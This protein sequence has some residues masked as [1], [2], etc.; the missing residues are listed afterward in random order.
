MTQ[1]AQIFYHDI[2]DYLTREKK[3]EI[4][5]EF[6]SIKNVPWQILTPNE[7]GDWISQRNSIF[8]TFIPLAPEKKFDE[9]SYA[10]FNINAI[11][12]S[13]NR[14]AWVYNFS[15]KELKK[16]IKKTIN[17]FN[18][19]PDTN[20]PAKISWTVNLKKDAENNIKHKFNENSIIKSLYRPFTEQ[21]LYYDKSLVER[22]GIWQQFFPTKE[23]KNL[24]ICLEGTGSN[25]GFGCLIT[26]KIS[27]LG[28]AGIHTQ[29]FPL[30]YYTKK[31]NKNKAQGEI[32]E[33]EAEYTRQNGVSDFIFNQ[34]K[35]RYGSKVSRED[36]FYYA[37]GIL[38]S[39]S[40]RKTFANDLK[41]MLPRL[42]LVENAE[43]FQ[44]FSASGRKL[45]KLHLNYEDAEPCQGLTI[46][47]EENKD[48]KVEQMRFPKKDKK[49][50]IIYNDK[51]T[52]SNIP[53]KAYEYIVNG[54]SAVEWVM[55]RYAITTHK[56]SGIKN[57]P[58]DWAAEHN[59][60]RYIL[61]LLLSV[62]AVSLETVDI[63]EGLPQVE[64]G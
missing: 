47:G 60:P 31:E 28:F 34:A 1:K 15:E 48:Y 20:D 12:V 32:F 52:I 58:N 5:K 40:Y 2:G 64:W 33:K 27:D 26:D 14:D 16:N 61:D 8:E 11:G 55:E 4:I 35:E 62:I 36:I 38:H 39:P 10:F 25:K 63:V 29:C 7:H 9:N 43:D 30:Y 13:T 45:A 56:D 46:T 24:V 42:P 41:K 49:D 44:A 50:T 51:I 54:K 23:Y 22:P 6:G 53:P 59:K 18:N 21:W 17:A 19:E 37:Y 3:L 57:N